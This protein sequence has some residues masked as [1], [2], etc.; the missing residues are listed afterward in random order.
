MRGTASRS[1][2][3]PEAGA[4]PVVLVPVAE[5]LAALLARLA[6]VPPRTLPLRA[7]EGR[8]L[9]APLVAPAPVPAA[10]IALRDGFAVAA[11]AVVGAAAYAPV[12]L[13]EP[14]PWV[15]AGERLPPGADCVLPPDGVSEAAG[16]FEVTASAA[17]GEGV[18]RAG[19]DAPAGAI[20]GAPGEALCALDLAAAEAAG[21]KACSVR[22]PRLRLLSVAARPDAASDFLQRFAVLAGAQV[23]NQQIGERTRDNAVLGAPPAD[24]IVMAGDRGLAAEILARHGAVTA[25]GLA[26]RPGE[27]A[28]C[29]R[30]GA[31]PVVIVPPRLDAALALAL[32]ILRPCLD[33]LADARPRPPL[34]RAPLT[35]KI[36]SGLGLTE[37]A[38][39]RGSEAGFEP[40]AVGDLPL[41]A[42]AKADAWLAVPPD[43]EGFAAGELVEVHRL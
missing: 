38:L 30:I 2:W 40:L 18:R 5:A 9:A 4:T 13:A 20:L 36:A 3:A 27:G 23:V 12:F 10:A 31:A 8:I 35:R 7:A 15:A 42:M 16:L 21:L 14:P 19:E 39:L 17:P 41:A 1:D 11:E 33:R 32:L 25:H 24:L 28:L 6:P 22:E 43:S 34:T 37:L 26:L 29:G